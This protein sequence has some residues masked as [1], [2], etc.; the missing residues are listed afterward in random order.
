MALDLADILDGSNPAPLTLHLAHT[1]PPL[2]WELGTLPEASW[3]GYKAAD[4]VAT[5][6]QGYDQGF[7]FLQGLAVFTNN[8]EDIVQ[9]SVA[10]WLT[11]PDA[12]VPGGITLLAVVDRLAMSFPTGDTTLEFRF[13]S[14]ERVKV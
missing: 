3:P 11:A 5:K 13:V 9:M 7:G 1:T 2:P 8:Q 12:E 10:A 4:F 14:F 6:R